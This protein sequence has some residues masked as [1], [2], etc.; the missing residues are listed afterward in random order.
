M[1]IEPF[2]GY[3]IFNKIA[4]RLYK[5]SLFGMNY[6]LGGNPETSGEY[7]LLY[8]LAQALTH[9]DKS[10]TIIFDVGANIGEYAQ[11]VATI[12]N[13][14][15]MIYA[16]EPSPVTAST[17]KKNTQSDENIK[18]FNIGLGDQPLEAE[19]YTQSANSTTASLLQRDDLPSSAQ[20][21]IVKIDTLTNFCSKAGVSNIDF[22]K[23]DVEGYEYQVLS[24][25]KPM[26]EAQQIRFIQFEIGPNN[27]R[28]RIFFKDFYDL[29]S[30]N[31]QLYRILKNGLAK[32]EG[33]DIRYENFMTTNYLA[34]SHKETLKH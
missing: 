33:Y 11:K 8:N 7:H 32:L 19:L 23:I 27:I 5:A 12:L 24:G 16:F 3:K 6:G 31:Y 34:C 2:L 1:K 4:F 18:V 21:E 28:N 17:L 26:I 13:T 15:Y 9:N 25:A 14:N 22:M 10:Q 30:S 29:L 20:Y